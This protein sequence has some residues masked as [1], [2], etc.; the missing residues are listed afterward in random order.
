MVLLLLMLL[1][2]VLGLVVVGDGDVVAVVPA[3]PH[4]LRRRLS[5]LPAHLT[6]IIP[7]S[8]VIAFPLFVLLFVIVVII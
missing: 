3:H 5:R 4:P 2:M 8:L 1:L 6:A 7:F